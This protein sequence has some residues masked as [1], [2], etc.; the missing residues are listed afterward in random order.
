MHSSG[1]LGN[2]MGLVRTLFLLG[3][4]VFL[5]TTGGIAVAQESAFQINSPAIQEG[6]PIPPKYTCEAIDVSPA[7][8]W[9]GAPEGAKSY[10]LI[11]EDPDAP[12]GIFVHWVIYNIPG[13][14]TGLPERVPQRP[15][16]RDG[17]VQGANDFSK[18]GYNGPCPPAGK[19]HR[20]YFI[21]RALDTK[22]DLPPRARKGKLVKA[23]KGHVLGET[24]LMGTFKR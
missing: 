20:Y 16:L 22:L 5:V 1:S 23:M 10:A 8:T 17:T 12:I 19:P 24:T 18:M 6:K 15:V 4:S 13:D 9:E 21:L 3:A 7:L 14:A 11:M 2:R